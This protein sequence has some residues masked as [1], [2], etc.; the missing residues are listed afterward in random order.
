VKPAESRLTG[1]PA[2]RFPQLKLGAG[3]KKEAG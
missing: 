2:N 3:N 1:V